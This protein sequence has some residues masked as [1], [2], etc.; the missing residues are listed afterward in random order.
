MTPI[1]DSSRVNR[2]VAWIGLASTLVGLL[3]TVAIILILALWV[4]PSEYGI[5][6]NVVWLFPVLD[7]TTDLGMS[8]AVIQRDDHDEHKLSTVFWLNLGIALALVGVLALVGPLL[9]AIYNQPVIALML[10]AYGSKLI[11]QNVYFI[12]L[13]QM[14]R[15]LRFKELSILRIIAN[16]AEFFGKVGFA[17]AGF[18]IWCFVLGPL[19]RVVV[20]GVGAQL[21][22]PWRPR[23]TFRPNEAA[24]YLRFGWKASSSQILYHFY[25]NVDYPIVGFFFGSAAAGIYKAA[26]ETVLYPVKAMSL[27]IVDIAFP[28]FA[29]LRN[30]REQLF[31]QFL[32]FTRLNAIFVLTFAG[33]MFVAAPDFLAVFYPK[34]VAAESAVRILC[35]VAVM[36]AVSYVIPPLLDGAGY[37]GRT[38]AYQS[39]AAIAMPL[40]YVLGAITLGPTMGFTS[41][42][43]AWALGYPIAFAALVVMATTA[44]DLPVRQHVQALG[45]IAVCVAAGTLCAWATRVAL[46]DHVGVLV[47]L[48]ATAAVAVFSTGLCLAYGLGLSPRTVLRSLRGPAGTS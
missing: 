11:W 7:Q 3:D 36:R 34:Y 43:W 35:L 5:A 41:V 6:A 27:V 21:R 31:A 1:V 10:L 46:A 26:F 2:G 17:A 40:A 30:A 15:E 32:S 42:A 45:S 48:L 9:A 38:L 20:T 4:S 25:T 37:P 18:G 14:R 13:A 23:L 19:C 29:R 16:V 47:R 39:L 44:L 8:A 22:R 24:E 12:P 33:A 28:T